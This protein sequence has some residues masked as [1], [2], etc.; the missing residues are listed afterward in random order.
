MKIIHSD[1]KKCIQTNICQHKDE[2]EAY[3]YIISNLIREESFS[4]F[5]A[6]IKCIQFS[7]VKEVK[8]SQCCNT[9]DGWGF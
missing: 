7:K 3:V 2:H 5:Q 4:M 6:G 9:Y 1:C 8:E